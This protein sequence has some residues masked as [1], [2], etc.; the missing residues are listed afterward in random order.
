MGSFLKLLSASALAGALLGGAAAAQDGV[1]PKPAPAPEHATDSEIARYCTALAP[2]EA[3]A[4]AANQL[5]RLAA[6][7]QQVREEVEKLETKQAAAREW[8]TR[9]EAMMKSATDDVVAIYAKMAPDAAAT[10]LS[11]ME[12]GMAAAVL[13][14]LKPATASAI[15]AEMEPDKAAKLS[16]L[17]AGAIGAERS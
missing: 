15:L 14:K 5:R 16:T 9:R 2:S 17:V 1:K 3:E 11:A 13:L 8:V 12:E 4:R 6:L 7:E 10:Q